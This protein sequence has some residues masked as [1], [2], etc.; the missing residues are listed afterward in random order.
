MLIVAWVMH[1]LHHIYFNFMIKKISLYKCYTF[2]KILLIGQ[3]QKV[4][5]LF[6]QF[7]L[8][9]EYLPLQS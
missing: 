9:K 5:L 8:Y 7:T 6:L 2:I 1:S 4:R 3:S